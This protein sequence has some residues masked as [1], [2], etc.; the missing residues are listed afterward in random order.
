MAFAGCTICL[1]GSLSQTRATFEQGIKALGGSTSSSVTKAT[2]HVVANPAEYASRTQKVIAAE[3]KGIPIVDEAWLTACKN[4]GKLAD[5]SGYDLTLAPA[6]QVQAAASPVKISKAAA[7]ALANAGLSASAPASNAPPA[8]AGRGS[9]RAAPSPPSSPPPQPKASAVPGGRASKRAAPCPPSPPPP[10]PKALA[11][12]KQPNASGLGKAV[13]VVAPPVDDLCP[14][15]DS[16]MVFVDPD[17]RNKPWS[18]ML[19]QTNVGQNNNKYYLLQLVQSK[20]GASYGT[21]FRWGRVGAVA[22]TKHPYMG[23]SLEAAKKEFCK[24]FSDKA[25]SGNDWTQIL[26]NGRSAFTPRTGKYTLV[27]MDYGGKSTGNGAGAGAGGADDGDADE[28]SEKVADSALSEEVQ[29]LVQ[30]ICDVRMIT[31]SLAQQGCDV[32]KM[33]LGKISQN[34]VREGFK[35]LKAIEAELDKPRPVQAVLME[36]SSRFFTVVPH[37]F[38]F[39]NIRDCVIGDAKTL[40]VKLQL[41]E[42]LEQLFQAHDVLDKAAARTRAQ[43]KAAAAGQQILPN[44]VDEQYERLRCQTTPLARGEWAAPGGA[45]FF[46][47]KYVTATHAS[48]HSIRVE[49]CNVFMV[50]RPDEEARYRAWK[51]KESKQK[52]RWVDNRALLWHG[53]RLTNW[54]GILSQGLRVAPPEAPVTGYMFGK[55]VYFADSFSK[56]ANYCNAQGRGATGLLLLCEVALGRPNE[57]STADYNAATL[58]AAAGCHSTYGMG[59]SKPDPAADLMVT[60]GDMEN[61]RVPQGTL[62]A[63]PDL[64]TTAG[65]LL[66]NEFIVYDI[67]QIRMRYLVEVKFS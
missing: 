4:Q 32:A 2:T 56:S 18:A 52:H 49:V 3:R 47:N 25:G 54:A 48:T 38:G 20:S 13:K 60:T 66:Y 64:K 6:K 15:H 27:E 50:H 19:N 12:A 58:C 23:A 29:A 31:S 55:G 9:K 34:M 11:A 16:K 7:K 17:H 5:T 37:D 22:G 26:S 21:W 30:L 59:R 39:K 36:L 51:G 24:K 8:P 65:H 61:V 42:D 62:K 43:K 67:A 41:V 40:K 44:P 33:P 35:A 53:S 28:G 45:H 10:Q 14:D 57:L 63:N 1:T 46:I